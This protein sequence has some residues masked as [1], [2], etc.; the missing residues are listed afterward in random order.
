MDALIEG[1]TGQVFT[2]WAE[3]HTVDRFLVFGQCVNANAPVHIP[4]SNSGV[5]GGAGRERERKNKKHSNRS[6]MILNAKKQYIQNV[7]NFH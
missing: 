5:E 3:G 4:Q 6:M 2:I 1:T 7:S